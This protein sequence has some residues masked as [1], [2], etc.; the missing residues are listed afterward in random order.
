MIDTHNIKIPHELYAQIRDEGKLRTPPV[1]A[2]H[3]ILTHLYEKYPQKP[4]V[5]P[6][7]TDNQYDV[8]KS[9]GKPKH[10]SL[11]WAAFIKAVP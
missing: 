11:A 5:L 7:L 2:T 9:Q 10:S 6:V 8:W 3:I 4:S 1:T